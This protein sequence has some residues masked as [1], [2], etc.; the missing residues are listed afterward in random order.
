MATT[1]R[2]R[3]TATTSENRIHADDVA[4]RYGFRGGLVPGVDVWA[5]LCGPPADRWGAEWV[6]MGG[7]RGRFRQP[8]YD[9]SLVTVDASELTGDRMTVV[10]HDADETLCAEAEAW[11]PADPPRPPDPDRWPERP[12]PAPADRPGASEETLAPGTVLGSVWTTFDAGTAAGHAADTSVTD[13]LFTTG[14]AAHPAWLLRLANAVL[15]ANVRLGP[16]IHTASTVQHLAAVPA[17]ARLRTAAVVTG[18]W[19]RNGHRFV[20]LDVCTFT[21]AGDPVQHVIHTAIW[22]PRPRS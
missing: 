1:I 13:P 2:A 16:W 18:C 22:Q 11:L 19:E 4:R 6:A 5:Y 9:G 14:R 12:A 10:V 15:V 8:V 3:N 21:D 17:P 7:M 20:E